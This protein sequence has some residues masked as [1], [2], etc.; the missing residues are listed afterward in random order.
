MAKLLKRKEFWGSIIALILLAICFKDISSQQMKTLYE[1]VSFYYLIPAIILEFFMIISRAIRWKIIIENTKKLSLYR[2]STLFS[3]GQVI[4]IVMPVLTGLVARIWLFSKKAGL[5]KSY[6]FST[7]LIEVLFDAI[8]MLGLILVLSMAF[9]FPAE[10]RQVSYIIAI[11]TVSS[12]VLLYLILT[13]KNQIGNLGRKVLRGRWPGVYITLKKFSYSFTK[14]ISLL[15]STRYFFRT[16]FLS[17]LSW[18]IHITVIYVLFKSFGFELPFVCAIVVMVINSLALMIPITPGN[19]GTFELAVVASLLA[20]GINKTDAV[21]FA[22]ALHILDL[23]PICVM[24][25]LFL[26]SDKISL[27]QLKE[28]GEREEILDDVEKDEEEDEEAVIV[29]EK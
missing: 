19:T 6:V 11:V 27:R 26:R 16:L 24:G 20:F 12:F 28:E 10:Y 8:S 23:I 3:A 13:F 9:V 2:V 18:L 21:L 1:R 22:L 14:G 15:R 4:N 25:F 5:R 17:I 7:V 29:E